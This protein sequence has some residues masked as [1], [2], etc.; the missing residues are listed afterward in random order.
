M[1]EQVLAGH[2]DSLAARLWV[3]NNHPRLGCV[4]LAQFVSNEAVTLVTRARL[5]KGQVLIKSGARAIARFHDVG[6][7]PGTG[8]IWCTAANIRSGCPYAG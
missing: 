3:R 8:N 4:S 6:T 5:V 7:F 2:S 1:P